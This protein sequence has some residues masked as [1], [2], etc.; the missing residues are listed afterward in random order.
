MIDITTERLIDL[1]EAAKLFPGKNGGTVHPE[2]VKLYAR[3]GKLGVRLETVLAGPRRCT[4]IESVARFIEAVTAAGNRN[5][6][7][8]DWAPVANRTKCE[9]A[10][11]N[12]E[13][14]KKLESAGA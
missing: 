11:A 9:A 4:S 5:S 13:A 14:H 2:T 1:E 7:R 12:R 3:R 10:R 6:P 8:P